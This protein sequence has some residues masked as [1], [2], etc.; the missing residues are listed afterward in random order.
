MLSV[1]NDPIADAFESCANLRKRHPHLKVNI[2][3][4]IIRNHMNS[5]G[6]IDSRQRKFGNKVQQK[7]IK[8]YGVCCTWLHFVTKFI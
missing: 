8:P 2:K 6:Y 7:H 1:E 4:P 5:W 3:Y